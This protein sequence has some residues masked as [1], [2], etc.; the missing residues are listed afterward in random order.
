[1]EPRIPPPDPNE[2]LAAAPPGLELTEPAM[3]FALGPPIPSTERLAR[4]IVEHRPGALLVFD[5]G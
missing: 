5:T 4:A 1:M 3:C 2:C